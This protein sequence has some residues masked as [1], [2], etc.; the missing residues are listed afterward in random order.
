MKRL[1]KSIIFIIRDKINVLVY[2]IVLK[3]TIADN[4]FLKLS[5]KWKRLIKIVYAFMYGLH[6]SYSLS[7]LTFRK[8]HG[9]LYSILA[10]IYFN[11]F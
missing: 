3:L 11:C 6:F 2:N 4:S 7:M 5:F 8:I 9:K 1:L 10:F